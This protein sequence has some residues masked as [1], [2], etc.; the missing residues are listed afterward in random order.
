[1]YFVVNPLCELY[2]ITK[3][4]NLKNNKLNTTILILYTYLCFSVK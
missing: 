3:Y 2:F 4:K 1:M